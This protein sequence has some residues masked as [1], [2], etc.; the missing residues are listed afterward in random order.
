ME[1]VASGAIDTVKDS[2]IF[3]APDGDKIFAMTNYML[4]QY[5]TTLSWLMAFM[6]V[7]LLMTYLV[8]TADSAVLIVNTINAAGDEGPKARPHIIFWG[9]ALGSVVAALF[10]LGASRPFKQRWSSERLPFSVVMVL[11]CVAHR[12][13]DLQRRRREKAG[14]A[15]TYPPS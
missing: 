10:W 5:P 4:P 12:E 11:Q 9:V 1:Q 3:A 6:I 7:V 14:L 15:T 13:G 2:E 8:T